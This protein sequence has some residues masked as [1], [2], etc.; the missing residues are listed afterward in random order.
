[1]VWVVPHCAR[2]LFNGSQGTSDTLL[3]KVLNIPLSRVCGRVGL[4][5]LQYCGSMLVSTS[6]LELQALCSFMHRLLNH[7]DALTLG[8]ASWHLDR[9]LGGVETEVRML[10]DP[11]NFYGTLVWC[12]KPIALVL[13]LRV[14][15]HVDPLVLSHL[16]EEP[17]DLPL[18]EVDPHGLGRSTR[19]ELLELVLHALE[20]R[21]AVTWPVYAGAFKPTERALLNWLVQLHLASSAHGRALGRPIIY[22]LLIR[23]IN[24]LHIELIGGVL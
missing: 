13:D 10:L 4:V 20:W 19:L 17:V 6:K 1:M 16:L 12:C 15:K 9:R 2:G 14:N 5:S 3:L 21:L 22:A 23:H 24:H 18:L 8:D 11:P 7:S